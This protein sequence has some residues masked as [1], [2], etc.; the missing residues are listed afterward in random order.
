MTKPTGRPRGRPKTK[1][2]VTLMARVDVTLADRVKRYAAADGV[3]QRWQGQSQG[4]EQFTVT[5]TTAQVAWLVM[6]RLLFG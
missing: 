5:T 2:S 6:R 1:E 4:S 3:S